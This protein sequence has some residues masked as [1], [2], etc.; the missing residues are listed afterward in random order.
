MSALL[1]GMLC[2]CGREVVGE[3]IPF[4]GMAGRAGSREFN[5][6]MPVAATAKAG[7][8]IGHRLL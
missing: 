3:G 2:H 6:A 7:V 1:A 4:G 5:M 8:W